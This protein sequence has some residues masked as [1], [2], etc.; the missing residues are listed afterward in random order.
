MMG[1]ILW[2]TARYTA[3]TD[4]RLDHVDLR[5]ENLEATMTRGFEK[6]DRR[7]EKIE[8]KLDKLTGVDNDL[9]KRVTA[10]EDALKKKR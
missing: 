6:I 8:E 5:I 10:L 1:G 9:D 2:S 7:F 4:A 3:Q